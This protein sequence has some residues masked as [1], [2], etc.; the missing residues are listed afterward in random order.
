MAVKS[1][2]KQIIDEFIGALSKSKSI[3][4]ARLSS[5]KELLNSEKVK[6]ENVVNLL[7]EEKHE[8]P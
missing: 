4:E 6:K 1:I 2:T 5:L 7:K 3:D 8:N